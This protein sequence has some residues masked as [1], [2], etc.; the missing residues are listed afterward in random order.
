MTG[1][2]SNAEAAKWSK[3][4]DGFGKSLKGVGR[5]GP[6][7]VGYGH[8]GIAQGD[9]LPAPYGYNV[10]NQPGQNPAM[11]P[12]VAAND[13]QGQY[14][15]TAEYQAQHPR[16]PDYLYPDDSERDTEIQI[17]ANLARDP[18]ILG[19][20]YVTPSDIQY[21]KDKK[22]VRELA[23]FKQFVE[24]SLPRGTP[25]AREYFERIMPG[26][27]QSKLDIINDKLSIINRFIEISIRG[28]Q[29]IDDMYIL[30]QLYSGKI[31]LPGNI[32]E[33]IHGNADQ[34][35]TREEFSSGL[36]NP[37]RYITDAI[38]I[39]KRNQKYMANFAIP[40]IDTKGLAEV[41]VYYQDRGANEDDIAGAVGYA[42]GSSRPNN[43]FV[44][45]NGF[46]NQTILGNDNSSLLHGRVA[47]NGNVIA[48]GDRAT[49]II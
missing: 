17:K 1:R 22:N 29:N 43:N 41:G 7:R 13:I 23:L 33:I 8:G 3:K 20:T 31:S 36:F 15:A 35:V 24:D 14:Q 11:I 2:I 48:R 25:W 21:I 16:Y 12:Y 45:G 38:R 9:Q 34:Q 40:G 39:S 49:S 10:A 28:P 42:T 5:G 47:D 32:Q 6:M 46:W 44:A 37:K 26:W 4:V 27:Y 19:E 18:T 30:Y